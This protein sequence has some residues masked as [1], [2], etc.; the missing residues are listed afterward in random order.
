LPDL[1][2]AVLRFFCRVLRALLASIVKVSVSACVAERD[3]EVDVEVLV[4][5]ASNKDCCTYSK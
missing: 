1:G 2:Q 5:G 3:V 4:V